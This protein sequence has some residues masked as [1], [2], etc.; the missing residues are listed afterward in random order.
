MS[1]MFS[2]SLLLSAS[3]GS[4][5]GLADLL[6]GFFGARRTN[7]AACLATDG[8]FVMGLGIDAGFTR[9]SAYRTQHRHSISNLP[10]SKPQAD[11][12]SRV[13]LPIWAERDRTYKSEQCGLRPALT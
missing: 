5:L 3:A 12:S 9:G 2:R 4:M 13:I 7:L 8:T 1:S 10:V 6:R 11:E